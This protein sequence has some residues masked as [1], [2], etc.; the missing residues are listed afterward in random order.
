M[1]RSGK[2][3]KPKEELQFIAS[4]SE[5]QVRTVCV[6]GVGGGRGGGDGPQWQESLLK[7]SL[8][9]EGSDTFCINSVRIKLNY[10]TPLVS[11]NCL[12]VL[13]RKCTSWN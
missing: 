9:P 11:E 6:L 13:E 4:L 3:I 5:A 8:Y 10:R 2:L 12:V 1:S 7:L